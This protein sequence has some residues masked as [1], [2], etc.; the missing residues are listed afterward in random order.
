MCKRF[1]ESG[2]PPGKGMEVLKR[3]AEF[4]AGECYGGVHDEEGD[5]LS[6]EG[7]E[8]VG[9]GGDGPEATI[10]GEH[11]ELDAGILHGEGDEIGEIAEGVVLAAAG[12]A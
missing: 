4:L 9:A 6:R 1:V 5:L 3:P 12:G 2:L 8:G 7:G 10:V 11:L